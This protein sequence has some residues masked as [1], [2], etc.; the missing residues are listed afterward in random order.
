MSGAHS[1]RKIVALAGAAIIL[2]GCGHGAVF[3]C[4]SP[5]KYCGRDYGDRIHWSP[6]PAWFTSKDCVR[7]NRDAMTSDLY[8]ACYSPDGA[9][10]AGG[11]GLQHPQA[12]ACH[13]RK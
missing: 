13:W 5:V 4:R 10:S 9:F 3:D 1:A 11:S 8:L 12:D 6:V 2:A 7:E